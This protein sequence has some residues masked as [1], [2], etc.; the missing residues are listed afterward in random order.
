[1]AIYLY[2][3]TYR[4]QPVYVGIYSPFTDPQGQIPVGWCMRCGRE[5]FSHGENL[6]PECRIQKGD[7]L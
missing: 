1:M 4:R 7:K 6:C 3:K 5:I 2:H